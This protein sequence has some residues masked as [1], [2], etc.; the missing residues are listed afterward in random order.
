MVVHTMRDVYGEERAQ[1]IRDEEWMADAAAAGRVALMKD[2]KIRRRPAE[3]AALQ[4]A[5]LR[6]FV[7]TNAQLPR[8]EMARWFVENLPR[9]IRT[10]RRPGPY[11]Y[12]V[13]DGR[14]ER[15]WP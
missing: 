9:I 13:Y 7:L 11:I 1:R 15:L 5:G 14:I 12:G 8:A 4:V 6:A 2:D 10:C 3:L